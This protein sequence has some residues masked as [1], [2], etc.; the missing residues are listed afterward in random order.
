MK[1]E[2]N[3]A[4]SLREIVLRPE[5]QAAFDHFCAL[6]SIRIAY[7]APSG[8]ELCAGRSRAQSCTYCTTLRT[9]LGFD[10]ACRALDRNK[11]A[12]AAATRGLVDYECHGGLHEAVM[13]VFLGASLAGFLMI[14]QFRTVKRLPGRVACS[15]QNARD[16]H[17]L[18]HAFT[19]TPYFPPEQVGHILGLFGL[20]VDS[21]VGRRMIVVRE[22]GLLEPL[23]DV[24]RENPDRNLS[25]AELAA[26]VHRSPAAVARRFRTRL[27]KGFKRVQIEMK[28]RMAEEWFAQEPG[29]TVQETAR[30]LGYGDP[31]YF[32]RLFR[33]YRGYPPSTKIAR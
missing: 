7:Y 4:V 8:R 31:L 14:G 26:K 9:E 18:A 5:V 21:L 15:C 19:Q 27:G 13:P 3:D 33:K 28:F 10:P 30:R 1:T 29:I 25:L 22:Q 17:A 23:I 11:R 6:L 24:L 12:E 32:S 20:L 2:G 16:R